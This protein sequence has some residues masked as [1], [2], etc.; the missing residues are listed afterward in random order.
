VCIQKQ[1]RPHHLSLFFCV[2]AIIFSLVSI[3]F[4]Q[5]FF[6]ENLLRTEELAEVFSAFKIVKLL[7]EVHHIKHFKPYSVFMEKIV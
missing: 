1:A 5:S 6:S 7:A 4:S 3:H 2:Y